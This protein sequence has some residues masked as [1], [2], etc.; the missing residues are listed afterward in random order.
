MTD[1]SFLPQNKRQCT[2]L[3]VGEKLVIMNLSGSAVRIF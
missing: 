2:V 1:E 3:S